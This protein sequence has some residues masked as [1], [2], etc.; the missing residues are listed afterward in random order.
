MSMQ[1]S[2]FIAWSA[3]WCAAASAASLQISPVIVTLSAA[4]TA[5]YVHLDN[6][7]KG[8]LY[9]QVRVFR[10]DQT[11]NEDML[12][13]T[14]EIVASPPMIQIAAGHRQLIRLVRT[15]HKPLAE[16][17]AY[18]ILIDE[19]PNPEDPAGA[20]VAVRLRYSVPLFVS[21]ASRR[22]PVLHW[23][24]R[25]TKEGP[26][27]LIQNAGARRAQIAAVEIISGKQHFPITNGL[28]GYALAGHT[29]RWRLP[30][31]LAIHASHKL[32]VRAMVNGQKVEAAL[33][34]LPAG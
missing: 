33:V 25:A 30:D 14:D 3:V 13:D 27:L 21:P 28:L 17:Q 18:R 10:W 11:I 24:I 20:G 4:D 5:A 22:Q 29:R 26:Y 32:R 19:I 16:E 15:G 23:D 2:L 12:A 6:V 8:A 1:R 31:D 9:G 7:T 34:Q